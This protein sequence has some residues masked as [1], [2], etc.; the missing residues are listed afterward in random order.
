ML[1][2][3]Q[4]AIGSLLVA[5]LL[6]GGC[7]NDEQ[8]SQAQTPQTQNSADRHLI[9]GMSA[10]PVQLGMTL[11][12]VLTVLP[13]ATNENG[14]DG[15]GIS[16]VDI[17]MHDETIMSLLLDENDHT[18]SLIRVFSPDFATEQ[19]VHVGENLQSVADKLGGLNEIQ[20]TEIEAR[21]FATFKNSPQGVEFQVVGGDGSAGVYANSETITTIA[22]PTATIQSIWVVED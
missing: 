10:G 8:S 4:L 2:K 3:K 12:D 13:E 14:Q 21:E 17:R 22:S 20:S 19:D 16:W 18:V 6:L 5:G 11:N 1:L 9:T 15:E 7:D